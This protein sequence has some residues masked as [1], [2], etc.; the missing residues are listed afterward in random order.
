MAKRAFIQDW[1]DTSPVHFATDDSMP[2]LLVSL[3]TLLLYVFAN[4]N[5]RGSKPPLVNPPK[6]L[7]IRQSQ[8]KLEFVKNSKELLRKGK[9]A[10]RGK[11]FRVRSERGD[12]T[13]L[14]FDMAHSMRNEHKLSFDR[15]VYDDFHAYIPGF[16]PVLAASNGE[17]PVRNVAMHQLTLV[18]SKLTEPLS[19]ETAFAVKYIFGDNP[20]W[21]DVQ[22]KDCLLQLIARI[23]SRV[24]LGEQLC[25]NDEWLDITINYSVDLFTAA[26]E[27]GIWPKPLRPIVHWFLP[28]VRKLRSEIADAREIITP[29]V[30][31]RRSMRAAA[32]ASGKPEPRFN[33]AIDWFEEYFAGG[34]PYDPAMLQINLS[35]GAIH[36]T[37]DLLYWTMIC[38]ADNPAYFDELRREIVQVLSTEGW[39]K[40][41][42]YNLKLLDSVIKEAQRLKPT[43]IANMRR[44]AEQDVDL[45]GGFHIKKGEKIVVSL[46]DMWS[47][48]RFE[49]PLEFN[50]HRWLKL[51]NVPGKEHSAHLVAVTRDHIGFGLGEHACPGRFFAAN[52]L[53]IVLSYLLLKYDWELVADARPT[54]LANGF[55]L[56]L[57]P[58]AKIR[59][60]RRSEEINLETLSV[61]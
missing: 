27:L 18:L 53:K 7:D 5:G 2:F 30:V 23:S 61:E 20:E 55:S 4:S 22:I 44:M 29:L 51:R 34:K 17:Q 47:A 6:W 56:T 45:P 57:D 35:V 48:E 26:K 11:P 25:R 32:V 28:S 38:I 3:M 8:A 59:M 54:V 60:R 13:V 12:V 16:E 33:D 46:T 14:P 50:G 39:K 31:N 43:S 40:T 41:S 15:A 19:S 36:T 9:E 10:F 1:F 49:R 24:F 58:K 37:T 21:H 42:L 52:E